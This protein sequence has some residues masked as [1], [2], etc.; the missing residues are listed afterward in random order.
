MSF[1]FIDLFAGIGSFH[2][3]MSDAGGKC[4]FASELDKFSRK[5]Y[6]HNFKD[7]NPELF[8][9]N[10]NSDITD[11]ELDYNDIPDFDVMC[12]GFPCQPFSHAGHKRGFDDTRGTLFF[13]IKKIAEAKKPKVIVLENVKGF[14]N[15]DKGRTF[16]VVKRT[17]DE[18]G[19][20]VAY[21]V[22]NTKHFGLP[23]NRERIFIVA[24]R[25]DVIGNGEFKFPYGIDEDNNVIYDKK[26]VNSNSKDVRVGDILLDDSTLSDLEQKV[27]R[28]YTISEKA[29]NSHK[30]RKVRHRANGNGFGY[31]SFNADSPYTNTILARYYKDGSEALIEQGEGSPRRLHPIECARLQ[32]FPIDDWFE[33]P[34]SDTQAYRQFGNSISVP[35]SKA[36]ADEVVKQ[37][38]NNNEV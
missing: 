20:E 13:N 12:A 32:G 37:L 35:V 38:L 34:V 30:E 21:D 14:V 25:R 4:V 8:D 27:N 22:L 5:T 26:N 24:W 2:I 31:S 6:E 19:Y 33:I 15:H 9:G 36:I 29:W 16:K 18:L 10:F 7:S 1:K 17:L 3:A 23:Q 28:S 11:P